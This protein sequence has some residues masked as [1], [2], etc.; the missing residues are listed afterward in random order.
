MQS[1]GFSQSEQFLDETGDAGATN[2]LSGDGVAVGIPERGLAEPYGGDDGGIHAFVA[3]DEVVDATDVEVILT[4]EEEELLARQKQRRL[5]S[6]VICIFVLCAAIVVPVSVT[7]SSPNGGPSTRAPTMSPTE[8]PSSAPSTVPTGV[9]IPPLVECLKEITSVESFNMR[10]SAQWKALNW[11][12]T[13][14]YVEDV[15]LRCDDK[16][17]KTRYAL[18]T[19]FFEMNGENWLDC[20][21]QHPDCSL[22]RNQFGWLSDKDVCDWHQV[23]CSG[24]NVTSLNFGKYALKAEG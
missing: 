10:G 12:A 22:N 7:V 11:I 2:G 4:E 16:R 5:V 20:G 15:G 19:M 9:A 8:Q 1:E 18:A 24:T 17:Y 6:I 21:L 3:D 23:R 13:E 14:P